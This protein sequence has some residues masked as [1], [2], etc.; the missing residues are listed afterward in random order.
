MSQTK[1]LTEDT[2]WK[3]QRDWN[4]AERELSEHSHTF[5]GEQKA[6]IRGLVDFIYDSGRFSDEYPIFDNGYRRM[7]ELLE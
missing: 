5:S 7:R 1:G 6:I 3:Y 2:I 4:K